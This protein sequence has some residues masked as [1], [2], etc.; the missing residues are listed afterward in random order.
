MLMIEAN[1]FQ[2]PEVD[3]P[4]RLTSA[5]YGIALVFGERRNTVGN[6]CRRTLAFDAAPKKIVFKAFDVIT[7]PKSSE[8]II[9]STR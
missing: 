1:L 9:T 4:P 2:P 5:Y 3:L 8:L 6:E 7:L